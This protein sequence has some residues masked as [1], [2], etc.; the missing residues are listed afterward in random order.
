MICVPI[1]NIRYRMWGTTGTVNPRRPY[2]NPVRERNT[3][4]AQSDSMQYGDR[5][6]SCGDKYGDWTVLNVWRH[7]G[8]SRLMVNAE[9]KCG[10]ICVKEFQQLD[11]RRGTKKCKWCPRKRGGVGNTPEYKAWVNARSRCHNESSPAY[12]DYGGRGVTMCERWRGSFQAF[13]EDMGPRPGKAYSLD[14]H[15]N[16]DG[17]YEPGNCR[18]ATR[19]EQAQNRRSTKLLT[20]NGET[21]CVGEWERRQ[22]F[23]HHT[24][25]NRLKRGWS[26]E[27]AI[28]APKT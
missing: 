17:N 24:I 2:H 6:I 8:T 25:N 23:S 18:W 22:G 9:C 5:V 20:L 15:P 16:N 7:P 1:M 21:A 13:L 3:V 27:E 12:P 14:R 10:R 11:G 28:L 26:V 4:M 19:R